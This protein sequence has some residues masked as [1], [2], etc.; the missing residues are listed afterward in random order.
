MNRRFVTLSLVLLVV[1]SACNGSDTT[2]SA[3]N[4]ATNS[5][6]NNATMDVQIA[7]V[8]V[9]PSTALLTKLGEATQFTARAF[10]SQGHEVE[11]NFTWESSHPEQ[12]A[13]D[14]KGLVTAMTLGSAVITAVADVNHANSALVMSARPLAGTHTV[15]D[16]QLVSLID[17]VNPTAPFGPG[18]RLRMTLRGISPPA[19]G[20]IV[21]GTGEAP[22]GGRVVAVTTPAGGDVIVTLEMVPLAEMFDELVVDE[23]LELSRLDPVISGPASEFYEMKKDENGR[24]ILTLKEGMEDV[25]FESDGSAVS[26]LG[27]KQAL[28]GDANECEI[29]PGVAGDAKMLGPF[30]CKLQFPFLKLNLSP[31]I[32]ITHDLSLPIVLNEDKSLHSILLK[33]Q[34]KVEIKQNLIFSQAFEGNVSCSKEVL[35]FAIPFPGPLALILGGAVKLGIGFEAGGKIPVADMGVELS[36]YAQADWEVGLACPTATDCDPDA[37]CFQKDF[38][39]D[40]KNTSKWVG[41]FLLTNPNAIELQ[42]SAAVFGTATFE[43]GASGGK[44][45]KFFSTL[46]EKL[47]LEVFEAKEGPVL[48]GKHR[49]PTA[50]ALDPDFKS[51][52]QLSFD[53]SIQAKRDLSEWANFFGVSFL[54]PKYTESVVVA[55]GPTASSATADVAEFE[56][57]D[58]VSFKVVLDA[59]NICFFPGQYNVEAVHIYRKPPGLSPESPLGELQL[60]A[61]DSPAATAELKCDFVAEDDLEFSLSW[62][63]TEAGTVEGNF[64]AFVDTGTFC[65]GECDTLLRKFLGSLELRRVTTVDTDGD[66]VPDDI[67]NCDWTPNPGQEPLA[68]IGHI[69]NPLHPHPFEGMG[70]ACSTYRSGATSIAYTCVGVYKNP[71]TYDDYFGISGPPAPDPAEGEPCSFEYCELVIPICTDWVIP[72]TKFGS[73]VA[74]N[75][76]HSFPTPI[77]GC[78]GTPS[79]SDPA[80]P[81]DPTR[82]IGFCYLLSY[83]DDR[84]EFLA[85]SFEAQTTWWRSQLYGCDIAA[86]ST[87]WRSDRGD[88]S[89]DNPATRCIE[90]GNNLSWSGAGCSSPSGRFGTKCPSGLVLDESSCH[91]YG[92]SYGDPCPDQGDL[93]GLRP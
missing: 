85:Q 86:A 71:Y 10:N 1:G 37:C 23:E 67:D 6:S 76:S 3:T 14:A 20:E 40:G 13:V 54:L 68:R 57:G 50:Q 46:A 27:T 55:S 87:I 79:P 59:E 32:P 19:V 63:A 42:T 35:E 75:C 70:R 82:S 36:G 72:S 64:F 15:T 43:A 51:S 91:I 24:L 81:A 8:E 58:V 92:E 4:S 66:G 83:P 21:M 11:A 45:S 33:G 74:L 28:A 90:I 53:F 69:D 49:A 30:C 5:A 29:E 73:P 18:V 56:E 41:S 7:R 22:I 65:S 60:V 2:S 12:L 62:T 77:P 61:T 47:S 17:V 44:L 16:D 52:H 25:S 48:Q 93:C 31:E 26:P 38:E 34:H 88:S 80:D 89:P 78:N 84:E 39:I 9:T